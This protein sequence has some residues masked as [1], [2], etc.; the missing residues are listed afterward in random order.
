M[1]TD[2]MTPGTLLHAKYYPLGTHIY[3]IIGNDP[4][5]N[6]GAAFEIVNEN[7]GR[8]ARCSYT[9]ASEI[10]TTRTLQS[11]LN[12]LSHPDDPNP[13][14]RSGSTIVPKVC[15][16]SNYAVWQ[17]FF[18]DM[19]RKTE[20]CIDY[21]MWRE[22]EKIWRVLAAQL[23]HTHI[24]LRESFAFYN[25]VTQCVAA[26]E[27]RAGRSSLDRNNQR[28]ITRIV[29]LYL[30]ESEKQNYLEQVMLLEMLT[31]YYDKVL[32]DINL[33]LRTMPALSD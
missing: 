15:Y 10:L 29:N 3:V 31:F 16:S 13:T 32:D 33:W 14:F 27:K 2:S 17:L 4:A 23:K 1:S 22:L 28:T 9:E 30:D 7:S 20:V 12:F 26:E 6:F 24:T 5:D 19:R 11:A 8:R 18:I 21:A 25:S